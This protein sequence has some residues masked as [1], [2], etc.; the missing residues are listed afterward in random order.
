M[1]A[2][3]AED[4]RV[5]LKED[6][7]ALDSAAEEP[8]FLEGGFGWVVVFAD[9]VTHS[10]TLGLLY[11]YGVIFSFWLDEFGG[12][13]AATAWPGSIA[14][15]SFTGTASRKFRAFVRRT[16]FSSLSLI[17]T[18]PKASNHSPL[19][20]LPHSIQCPERYSL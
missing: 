20:S 14:F 18:G 9:F 11:S 16:F 13:H 15:A 12:T 1:A 19:P 3:A 6:D 5:R 17:A 10:C 7:G 4:P 2:A 8:Q